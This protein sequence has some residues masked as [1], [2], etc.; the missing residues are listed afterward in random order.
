MRAPTEVVFA[1]TLLACGAS[2]NDPPPNPDRRIE[3]AE[4]SDGARTAAN[5]VALAVK[6]SA[7]PPALG[8]RQPLAPEPLGKR[9]DLCAGERYL[10][11]PSSTV[12][13]ATAFLV[14][15]DVVATA[16]HVLD[17]VA[18]TDLAFAFGFVLDGADASVAASDVYRAKSATRATDGGDWALVTLERAVDGRAP[19][20]LR[21]NGEVPIGESIIVVGHPLALPMKVAPGTVR[22]FDNGVFYMD[23]DTYQGNSGSPVL[24]ADTFEV[25]GLFTSGGEDFET[26]TDGCKKAIHRAPNDL[27][28]R[29]VPASV[30]SP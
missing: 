30:L 7:L 23:T 13:F 1:A 17:P 19:L 27:T 16:G 11:Q 24:N 22:V 14:A 10:D 18:I 15:P 29:A 6:R 21:R 20:T 2:T 4:A 3:I 5:S 8:G 12:G 9:V 28:E 26:T 25:E